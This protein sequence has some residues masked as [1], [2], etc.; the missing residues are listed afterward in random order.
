MR[1]PII[2][3]KCH[4]KLI[5]DQKAEKTEGGEARAI[6]ISDWYEDGIFYCQADDKVYHVDLSK[7]KALRVPKGCP[8]A[9]QHGGQSSSSKTVKKHKSKY[10]R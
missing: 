6:I 3:R 8:F 4:L 2:C 9:G 10:H 1:N 7:Y 5:I